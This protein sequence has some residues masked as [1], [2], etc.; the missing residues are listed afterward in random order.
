MSQ[1]LFIQAVETRRPAGAGKPA[2]FTGPQRA[3]RTRVRG[4]SAD[5][6]VSNARPEAPE[7]FCPRMEIKLQ[8]WDNAFDSQAKA[9]LVALSALMSDGE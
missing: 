5:I 7:F 3:V 9:F 2:V 6:F 4:L 1:F 8:Q